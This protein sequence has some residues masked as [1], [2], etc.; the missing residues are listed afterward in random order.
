MDLHPTAVVSSEARLGRDVRVGP[1]AVIEADSVVGDGCEIRAHAVVKRYTILGAGNHVHEHAVLGGEPQDLGFDGSESRLVIGD[2]NVIREFVSVHR[3]SKP[4]G[5]TLI[6]SD[7]FLM[8]GCHVAH[9]CVLGDR[10][11]MANGALLSGHISVGDRAFL[12]GGVLSHQFCRIG[13]LALLSGG[14]RAPMDC[15]PFVITE[16]HPAR[17]R[18]VNVIG[19]RR[20]GWNN[21]QIRTV[22]EAFRILVR[23]G[24][25]LEIALTRMAEL[26]DPNVDEMVSFCR[27]TKR[28]FHRNASRESDQDRPKP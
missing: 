4:G 11:I 9:D 18:A 14:A 17:A 16:G 13:R 15:L 19:L 21:A 26:R 23:A 20:A 28:G 7:C 2:R 3:A 25:P 22:K 5:A 8:A 1:Y 10:V 12:S 6:G 27:D 24:L